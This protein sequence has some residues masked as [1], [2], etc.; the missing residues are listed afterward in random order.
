MFIA[1]NIIDMPKDESHITFGDAS[2]IPRKFDA[3]SG[4][5]FSG[6]NNYMLYCNDCVYPES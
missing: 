3:L 4:D 5:H 1:R 6:N 2:I